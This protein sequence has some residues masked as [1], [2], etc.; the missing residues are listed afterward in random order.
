MDFV[1]DQLKFLGLDKREIQ[2]FTA[3]ST[4]GRMNMTKIASRSGLPR[5]TVYD[6]VRRLLEQ[7][8][9]SKEKIKNHYEYSANLEEVADKLDWL[10]KR[11]RSKQNKCGVDNNDETENVKNDEKIVINNN[12]FNDIENSLSEHYG[13]RVRLVL[14]KRYGDVNVCTDRFSLYVEMAIKNNIKFEILLCS[15]VADAVRA[16]GGDVPMPDDV[17]LIRLNIVPSTYCNI[18]TDIFLFRDKL[19]LVDIVNKVTEHIEHKSIVEL[20]KHLVN[21]ACETGWSVNLVAW[22][23]RV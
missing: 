15:K 13:D 5:T 6:V 19:I 23:D 10:E 20:N 22:L 11:L 14:S 8:L 12:C 7:G 1:I 16:K 17:N 9:I 4:F 21:I 2:V 18:V 3:I